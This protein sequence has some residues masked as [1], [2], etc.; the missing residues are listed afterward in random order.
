MF[1]KRL[2]TVLVGLPIGVW[3]IWRGGPWLTAA[4]GLIIL[5]GL[6]ELF[7]L[8]NSAQ[9]VHIP[10]W[11]TIGGGLITAL[12]AYIGG[13]VGSA[14]FVALVLSLLLYFGLRQ[15]HYLIKQASCILFAWAYWG[16]L[17]VHVIRLRSLEHGLQW[18]ML[19]VLC[20]WATDI[21]A[22]LVGMKFG[23]RK[24]APRISP[25]KS[26]EGAMGGLIASTLTAII[27]GLLLKFPFGILPLL[28]VVISV[29]G[30]TGDLVE[31]AL[32]REAKVKDSGT[33][34]PGH[35]GILDRFD[36]LVFVVPVVYHL[37]QLW[38][39]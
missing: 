23:K 1:R 30:Q 31:S 6:Y 12:A 14:L 21:G 25:N 39:R 22:Y 4:V 37:I 36:S 7:M 32:K 5:L 28:G 38:M 34:F 16:Y 2:V 13:V 8:L 11:A 29:V 35:G 27:I 17:P 33:L 26:V 18:L 9:E 3:L 15:E 20:T 24:L 10:F 19:A